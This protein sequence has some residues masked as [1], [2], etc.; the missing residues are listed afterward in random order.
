MSSSRLATDGEKSQIVLDGSKFDD[1]LK[2]YVRSIAEFNEIGGNTM[3]KAIIRKKIG[4]SMKVRRDD[5]FQIVNIN[6]HFFT[7]Q[8]TLCASLS[9]IFNLF[10][11]I[12][13]MHITAQCMRLTLHIL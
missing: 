12:L 1:R 3:P 2:Y 4:H 7:I 8:C 5:L 9:I 10:V 6:A 13:Y 11:H